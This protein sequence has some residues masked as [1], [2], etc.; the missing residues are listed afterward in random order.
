MYRIF[1]EGDELRDASARM[2]SIIQSMV[3]IQNIIVS[4]HSSTSPVWKG[5]ASNR[6]Q[7]NFRRIRKTTDDFLQDARQTKAALDEAVAAYDKIEKSQEAKV[8]QLDTKGI[9]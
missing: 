9:F 1:H 6:N 8:T 2:G 3:N 7:I 5:K 4:I